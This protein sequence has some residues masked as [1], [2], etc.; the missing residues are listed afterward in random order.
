MTRQ[1]LERLLGLLASERGH[2]RDVR[3]PVMQRLRRQGVVR[4]GMRTVARVLLAMAAMV[5]VGVGV[6]W[7]WGSSRVVDLGEIGR[8]GAGWFVPEPAPPA[9]RLQ[10]RTAPARGDVQPVVAKAPWRRT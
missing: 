2:G 5:C 3:G 1:R 6:E 4:S 9:P 8:R 10:P 7:W